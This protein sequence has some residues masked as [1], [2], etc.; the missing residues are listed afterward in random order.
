MPHREQGFSLNFG[1][2]GRVAYDTAIF[3]PRKTF[4]LFYSLVNFVLSSYYTPNLTKSL[5]RLSAGFF[6]LE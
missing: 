4:M 6:V 1:A 5:A 3:R 2:Q